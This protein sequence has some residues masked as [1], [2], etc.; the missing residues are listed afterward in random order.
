MAARLVAAFVRRHS[1][2]VSI[3]AELELEPATVASWCC[4]SIGIGETTIV[5]CWRMTAAGRRHPFGD[6]IWFDTAARIEFARS[7]CELQ[8]WS[9]SLTLREGNRFEPP[10]RTDLVAKRMR[11][12]GRSNPASI[13]QFV[14]PDPDGPNSTMTD[15][16]GLCSSP[17]RM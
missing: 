4:R 1:P 12:L 8:I 3:R 17:R 10:Y 11:F 16:A 13:E 5:R 6:E 15:V 7:A 9:L 2:T 14:F